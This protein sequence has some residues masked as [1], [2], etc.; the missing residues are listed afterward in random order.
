MEP[1]KDNQKDTASEEFPARKKS[2]LKGSAFRRR[3]QPDPSVPVGPPPE[4]ELQ[5]WLKEPPTPGDPGAKPA[6]QDEQDD[7]LK[8]E[9]TKLGPHVLVFSGASPSLVYSDFSR[10]ANQGSH[11]DDWV[12]GLGHVHRSVNPL[13]GEP[14]GEYFL[15]FDTKEAA[16]EYA[17]N[18]IHRNHTANRKAK[19]LISANRKAKELRSLPR[20]LISPAAAETATPP[21]SSTATPASSPPSQVE[22]DES[23]VFT[24]IPPGVTLS[25]KVLPLSQVLSHARAERHRLQSRQDSSSPHPQLIPD[26]LIEYIERTQ[27]VT[28][29]T[30]PTPPQHRMLLCVE[31]GR[32][33]RDYLL[34][35]VA[36]LS[37]RPPPLK[38]NV[39]GIPRYQMK[40]EREGVR[41]FF[42]YS[43]FI[44]DFPEA[45]DMEH[46]VRSFHLREIPHDGLE[47]NVTLKCTRLSI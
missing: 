16:M 45:S 28:D 9:A 15:F 29:S 36:K 41:S 14:R 39:Q 19:E 30:A 7:K 3:H 12:K 4:L 24:L 21:T 37:L 18:I 38:D 27:T 6:L 5:K 47:H 11:L 22:E 13:T 26:G 10:V 32:M 17:G 8:T 33:A 42:A 35:T 46:F 44:V 25:F 43:R 31:G 23:C 20:V 34:K 40:V 2:H 1:G